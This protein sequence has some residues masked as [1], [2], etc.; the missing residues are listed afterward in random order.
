MGGIIYLTAY[1]IIGVDIARRLA[2]KRGPIVRIWLGLCLGLVMLMWFPA[3]FAFAMDFSVPAQW[4]GLGLAF[5]CGVAAWFFTRKKEV[6]APACSEIP[7]KMLLILVIPMFILGA[8]LQSTHTIQDVNGAMHVGQSTYGDLCLH[9]G[10][11]TG[12]RNASFPP[13]YTI[14]QG[15]DL[16]YPFLADTMVTSLMLMGST[17]RTAYVFTGSLMMLLVFAGYAIFAWELTHS[18]MAV[19]LSYI[20]MFINGGLGFIYVLDGVTSDSTMLREVFT[21]FYRTPTNMPEYNLRWVN[22]ICDMMVPQR[23]LLTGWTVLMPA[24]FM[25]ICAVNAMS[26]PHFIALG[27]WAGTMPM[28]H[29][30][31]FL[32]LGL[33]SAGMMIYSLIKAPAENRRNVLINFLVYGII[34]VVLAAPQLLKWT[35]PQTAGGGSLA[36]R[37]NWVNNDGYGNF[38]DGYFWFW[39]KNVG[40]VYL[41]MIP[42]ALTMHKTGKALALGALCIYIIAEIF[43]FQPN[44]YDNNKLFYVA[45]IAV[46]P[47]VGMYVAKL[48][49]RLRGMRIRVGLVAVIVILATISGLMSIGREVVSDY[50]L[51]SADEAAAGMFA[52]ENTPED[53]VILTGTHHN[54]PISALSGRQIVCGP[55]NYLYFHGI[56]YS[57]EQYDVGAMYEDP[58]GNAHLFEQY[59]VEYVYISSWE[60]GSHAVDTDW[61]ESN[62]EIVFNSGNVTIYAYPN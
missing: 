35:F 13:M 7:W 14:I 48:Y 43:Q 42:A 24:L 59:G 52:D 45:Y 17:L 10:I 62:C 61:F 19:V 34:T 21:G 54:N 53:T 28:I 47:M 4:C 11:A 9:L 2:A 60:L 56:D 41:L 1:E 33:I 37:F 5:L 49:E 40:V 32:G 23:T 26:L 18:R 38:I 8:F 30:H 31:S 6:P 46:T 27:V 16:G 36:V 58:A 15:V 57:Q 44:P 22:V 55:G 29:T 25:L 50:Q 39:I 3:L 20:F 12:Q 51:F